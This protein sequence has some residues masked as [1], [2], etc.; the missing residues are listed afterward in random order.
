MAK[1]TTQVR[2][3]CETLL[4]MEEREGYHN[5][6]EIVSRVRGKIFDF[7]YPIFDENYRSVL[8]TKI[9]KH[10]YT[11]EIGAE[12]M[13]LWK[14]WLD[15]KL[16]EIM[17]YYNQLYET[18]MI[19]F[20]PLYDTDYY[21]E[22][23]R[24]GVLD[25]KVEQN[26]SN[27]DNT[28]TNGK[29]TVRYSDTPQGGLSGIQ[30]NTYLTNV[31][32][33][34]NDNVSESTGSFSNSNKTDNITTEDYLEHVYGKVSNTAYTKIIADLRKNILNIDM[35]IIGDLSDLFFNLW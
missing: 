19:K 10:Y 7:E 35:Q 13:G 31:T 9:L 2:T 21:R 1:Y 3:I 30:N 15:T 26:G 24:H 32:I 25:G 12:T 6:N 20:N 14:L 29:Q 8:E 22:G 4:G 34:D 5:V 23:N 33:T 27:A 16:N 18:V 28:E 11:R 17:P